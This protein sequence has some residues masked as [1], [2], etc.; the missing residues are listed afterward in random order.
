MKKATTALRMFALAG[1]VLIAGSGVVFG[2]TVGEYRSNSPVATGPWNWSSAGTWQVYSASG[3]VAATT[4]PTGSAPKIT[5]QP[6][7][8]VYVDAA[9]T[10]TD[11]LYNQGILVGGSNLA[12]G[13]GGVYQHAENGGSI[14]TATWNTGST[15]LVT[16]VTSGAPSNA[17]QNFYNFTWNCPSQSSGLNLAWSGNTIAGNLTV[18]STSTQQFRMSNN[19]ANA[20]NPITIKILGNVLVDGGICTPTGSGGAQTYT[21][22]DSGNIYVTSGK[23]YVSGGSGGIVNWKCYGDTLSVANGTTL[24][25]SNT[26]SRWVFSKQGV[27]SLV[28]AG[29]QTFTGGMTFEVDTNATLNLGT[30]VIGGSSAKFTLDSAGTVMTAQPTGLNGNLTN[31]GTNTFSPYGGFVYDGTAAQVTGSLLPP[32]VGNLTINNAAGVTLTKSVGVLNTLTL[33]SGNLLLDTNY[34]MAAGVSGASS[35][36]YAV[37]DSSK[38]SFMVPDVGATKVL[39]PVGTTVVGYSPVWMTNGGT[40]DTFAVAAM[41]DSSAAAGGG[42]VNVKWNVSENHPG[43]GD[44]GLTFGWTAAAE[45]TLFA[46]NPASYAQIYNLSGTTYVQAGTGN[47]TS[48]L[49]TAPFTLARGGI[50][51]LGSFGV[52]K[53]A[54]NVNPQLGDYG[55]VKSGPWS[56]LSTWMQWNGT[57]WGTT[58]TVVPNG[59]V[60]VFINKSDTVT[61]DIADSI[62]GNM[63]VYGFLKDTTGLKTAGATVIFDSASTFQL[64]YNGASGVAGIPTA[65]WK[66]GSTCLITGK[67][68]SISSTSGYNANQDFYNLTIDAAFTKNLNLSMDGNTIY[69]D[70]LINNTGTGRVYFTSP[71]STPKTITIMGNIIQTAGQFSTN[72][73]GSPGTIIVNSYGNITATGG[74]FSLSRGSGPVVTWN[75]YGDSLSLSNT[76]SQVS[77]TATFIFAKHGKQYIKFNNVT[78]TNGS[79]PAVVDTGAT[80]VM[81]TNVWPGD[82]MFAADSGATIESGDTTGLDGN[83]TT[84]GTVALSPG[85]SYVFNGAVHQTTGLLL[86]ATVKS[87][88]IDNPNGVTLSK[89]VTATGTLTMMS[90]PLMLDTNNVTA[91]SA[92]SAATT[93]YVST[94]SAKSYLQIPNVGSKA[95]AFPVGTTAEGYSPVWITNAGTADSYTVNASKDTVTVGGGGRVNVDWKIGEGTAGGSNLTLQFGWMPSAQNS[96]FAKDP[97]SNADIY[98]LG[99]TDT[100]QAGTGNYTTQLSYAPYTVSR[101]G[102]TSVGTFAVGNFSTTGVNE[103]TTVPVVF[104]LF[105]NFPNP[106]NPTTKI[107]F[108]VEKKGMATV[109]VYN[110]LGQHVVTLF[111]GEAQPGLKYSVNFNGAS[112]ASGVYFSVLESNG[113]RQIQKMVLMK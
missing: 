93:S 75:S 65:T 19:N 67:D 14:P 105:Q 64:A 102:I 22:I 42:R 92:V 113:Q 101:A 4:P 104:K 27:Q 111:S 70:L 80:L 56:S 58:P 91:A 9:I 24:Q 109:A 43:Y 61:V 50:Q 69:G 35:S 8:S 36:S 82:G 96:V 17:N 95:V 25:T 100:T 1:L 32:T 37:T 88:T 2:Q 60:N 99:L 108:S 74:N 76:T 40:V 11:T 16:G 18:T 103:P 107:E 73:S 31:G 84:T 49:T 55:S 33:T 20:G 15:C 106:F 63:Q 5:I 28:T 85:V 51:T 54:L 86:P 90:G 53:F 110:I 6:T 89:S 79:L 57:T 83:I 97:A 52:G 68:G 3:W 34:V 59:E 46:A 66:T 23:L 47:Y 98:L 21:I 7:D 81:G 112:Y 30:S 78:F 13:N 44:L 62:G 72:G 26:S 41:V 45:N 87:L 39:F 48:Q 12:F 38:S 94:D 77:G 71:S 10:L 29:T